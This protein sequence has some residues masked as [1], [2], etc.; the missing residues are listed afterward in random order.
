MNNKI[1]CLNDVSKLLEQGKYTPEKELENNLL[2]YDYVFD[3]NLSVK[4][5][6]EMVQ[7]HNKKEQEKHREY[8]EELDKIYNDFLNDC[9]LAIRN[10]FDLPLTLCQN[11]VKYAKNNDYSTTKEYFIEI[12]GDYAKLIKE[13]TFDVKELN[14]YLISKDDKELHIWL[15]EN[16]PINLD[17]KLTLDSTEKALLKNHRIIHTVQTSVCKTCW[18]EKG[19]KIYVHMLDNTVVEMK[20]GYIQGYDKEIR[21][22]HNLEKMLLANAFGKA[23]N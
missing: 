15:S 22:S 6:R 9:V 17:L 4:K 8:W 2:T 16:Y 1:T 20:L 18:L 3:E 19:Y 12:L 11:I 14:T 5:N 21:N 7:E 23:R 10:E 13:T